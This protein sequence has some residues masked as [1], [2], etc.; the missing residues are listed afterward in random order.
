ME[1]STLGYP[2]ADTPACHYSP[3]GGSAEK[4]P[5]ANPHT[6]SPFLLQ[7]STGQLPV[8]FEDEI[9][10]CQQK[11]LTILKVSVR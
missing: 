8:T 3:E 10:S 1:C 2:I 6:P 11:Q 5:P 7:Y 4:V 9:Q